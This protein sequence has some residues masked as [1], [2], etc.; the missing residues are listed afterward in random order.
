MSLRLNMKAIP[1]L[2]VILLCAIGIFIYSNSFDCAFQFDDES[3]IVS[4]AAIKNIHNIENIWNALRQ[5]T[6]FVA[7][8]TFALNYHFHQLQVFGYHVVNLAIH[9]LG[10]ILVWWM[11]H[12]I[13]RTPRMKRERLTQHKQGIALLTSLLFLTHPIQT[14]AV[15]YIS[16]RFTSLAAFF[17]LLTVC[18]Y[19]KGRMASRPKTFLKSRYFAGLVLTIVLG[20]FTKEITITL[21][22]A[23]IL[24]ELCFF[25][26]LSQRLPK[27]NLS[28]RHLFGS[29][30]W[31]Y[32]L[33]A[34]G[35]LCIIPTLFRFKFHGI[36]IAEHISHSH[37]GDIMTW[38]TYV[39]SQFRVLM[40][41]FKLLIFPIGQSLDY[42]FRLSQSFFETKTF[43]SFLV[44]VSILIT[45]VKLFSRHILLAFGILWFFLTISVET[46]VPIRNIIFEHRVYL[47]SV[48]FCLVLSVGIFYFL[49][50]PRKRIA[51]S[52]VII[53][54]LSYLTFQRNKVWKD[55]IVFWQDV[56]SK[57]PNKA[58]PFLNLGIGYLKHGQ[59]DKAIEAYARALALNPDDPRTYNNRGLVYK[60]IGRYDLALDDYNQA[61]VLDPKYVK[62]Y[63]NRGLLFK[64]M[65]QY[66]LA[67]ADYNKALSLN[68]YYANAYNNRGVIYGLVGEF[69]KAF[70]DFDNAI[71]INPDFSEVF[72]NRGNIYSRKKLFD[73][74]L[75]DYNKALK[76]DPFYV[77]AYNNRGIAYKGKK[78]FDLAMADFYRAIELNP[79]LVEAYF[80]RASTLTD[81]K[82]YQAA[83]MEYDQVITLRPNY[84][85][86]YFQKAYVY[87]VLKNWDKALDSY[88]K[89]IEINPQAKEAYFH[90]AF[91]H[92]VKGQ[93]NKAFDDLKVAQ[94][95]GIKVDQKYFQ[96]LNKVMVKENNDISETVHARE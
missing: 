96:H 78:Q 13:F 6:R 94:S 11:V 38:P 44:L 21:P 27:N 84:F 75:Q 77:K 59:Y 57:V 91:I 42:D 95:L 17:Y 23:L 9:I 53:L 26:S 49:N 55:D 50:Q 64:A 87:S 45:A 4:N 63:S 40:T 70:V 39:M 30:R 79:K 47:P 80:N 20:M 86:A 74:A 83:L 73:L 31:I 34:L 65:R 15:T 41:Y 5:H 36:F 14:Q 72:N 16:Q 60:A 43:L 37:D 51:A 58:R 93:K 76:I 62:A 8:Y 32:F 2:S 25:Q 81:L 12:L 68:Q 82:K 66:R 92:K 1:W 69:D 7:F 10:S 52:L 67:F 61:L 35:V 24:I 18:I 54:V 85:K 19:L 48:G 88:N 29:G 56:I 46:F 33:C 3:Y 28:L 22:F 89:V 71:R 90:R